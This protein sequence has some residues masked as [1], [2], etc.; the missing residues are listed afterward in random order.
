[1]QTCSPPIWIS[2]IPPIETSCNPSGPR[3]AARPGRTG[4]LRTHFAEVLELARLE[5]EGIPVQVVPGITAASAMAE[6]LKVSLTHRDHAQTLRLMTA[7]SRAGSLPGTLDL[8]ALSC[9]AATTVFYM[10]RRMADNLRTRLLPEGIRPD[11]PVVAHAN[12][13]RPDER[14]WTGALA[15]LT[16]ETMAAFCDA[17]VLIGLGSVFGKMA[18]GVSQS[19]TYLPG[20]PSGSSAEVQLKA[21]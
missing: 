13:S 6:R 11:L 8:N 19:S 7:P 3:L 1:M 10:G 4:R 16:S 15:D 21:G 12:V 14:I 2:T 20:G 18:A 5:A 17:P 9:G